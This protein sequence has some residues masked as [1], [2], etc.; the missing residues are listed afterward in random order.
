MSLADLLDDVLPEDDDDDDDDDFD[1]SAAIN[2][3]DFPDAET[4]ATF[5]TAAAGMPPGADGGGA[6]FGVPY[7]LSDD[8]DEF[9]ERASY[10]DDPA[11]LPSDEVRFS[12]ERFFSP[13][14]RDVLHGTMVGGDPASST[15]LLTGVHPMLLHQTRSPHPERPARMVAIYH[16]IIEQRLDAR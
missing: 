5:A 6:S 10:G 12:H 16:E 4:F 14:L 2:E 1:P 9:D 11:K 7:D 15:G 8:D 13:R 3:D